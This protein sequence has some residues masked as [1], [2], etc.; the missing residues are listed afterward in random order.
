MYRDRIFSILLILTILTAFSGFVM[1]D[2]SNEILESIVLESFDPETRT[3]EWIVRGS[4]FITEGF[5]RQTYASA[6]PTALHGVNREGRDFQVLGINA[7]FDRLG[8]NY[9]EIIPVKQDDNG[10]TVAN[11]LQIPGRAKSI[12]LWV[13]GS[14]FDYYIEVD[15]ED[16]TGVVWTLNLGNINF[17]GWRNMRAE[18]PP[19]IPQ[20][21][22]YIPTLKTLRLVKVRL[23]TRPYER[24]ANFFVYFDQ[25]KVLTDTYESYFDGDSLTWPDKVQE[26]WGSTAQ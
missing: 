19:Y 1:A 21:E 23:W 18:I 7:R 8:Y 12:D 10:N 11:P 20:S 14:R 16:Y 5:P 26:I 17:T 22:V 3:S 24:V 9:L 25:I 15:V 13:W 4:K 2:E 6:W